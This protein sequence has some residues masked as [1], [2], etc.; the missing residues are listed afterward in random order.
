MQNIV[1]LNPIH[2]QQIRLTKNNL[3]AIWNINNLSS[4]LT[5]LECSKYLLSTYYHKLL[6]Y[7]DKLGRIELMCQKT[8]N[9]IDQQ[10]AQINDIILQAIIMCY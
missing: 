10:V 3:N 7:E 8:R 2:H 6:I 1:G 9:E 5:Q 4:K